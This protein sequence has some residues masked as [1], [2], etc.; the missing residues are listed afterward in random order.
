MNKNNPLIALLLSFTVMFVML[1]SSICIAAQA[2]HHCIGDECQVCARIENGKQTLRK[3]SA[4]TMAIA[5]MIAATH[6]IQMIFEHFEKLIPQN[7]LVV[8]KVK[9]SN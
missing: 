8:L 6:T 1:L 3:I 4:V 5:V 2:D 9:L 7:T